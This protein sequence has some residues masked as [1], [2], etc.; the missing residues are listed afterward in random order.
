MSRPAS[1]GPRPPAARRRTGSIVSHELG[2]RGVI[3]PYI[4]I[5]NQD[6]FVGSTG[7]LSSAYGAFELNADPGVKGFQVR[8]LSLPWLPI[9]A[10]I[11]PPERIIVPRG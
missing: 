1:A 9:V 3:P 7:F 4:A 5:P 8:D 2:G 6:G 11:G 10:G